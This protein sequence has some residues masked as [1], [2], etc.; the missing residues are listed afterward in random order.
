MHVF[1]AEEAELSC[2]ISIRRMEYQVWIL[3]ADVDV[4]LT[5]HTQ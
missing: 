5:Q 4:G 3:N 2:T 1:Y